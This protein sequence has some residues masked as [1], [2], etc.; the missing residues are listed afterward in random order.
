[1]NYGKML[2]IQNDNLHKSLENIYMLDIGVKLWVA[3][4][5][6]IQDFL[7]GGSNLQG[8]VKFVYFT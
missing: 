3:C 6:R 5:G 7:I 8:V 4:Q 1:M 2:N